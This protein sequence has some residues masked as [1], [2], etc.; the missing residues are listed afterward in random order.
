[1]DYAHVSSDG[2]R[3]S[4]TLH[5]SIPRMKEAGDY[6]LFLGLRSDNDYPYMNASVIVEQKLMPEGHIFVDTVKIDLTRS[7]GRSR[8]TGVNLYQF[9]TEV[10]TLYLDVDDSLE[11]SIRHDIKTDTLRGISDVGVELMK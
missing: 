6:C 3:R 4:D 5:F 10:D 2:W 1:M 8:G 9:M 7:N 11:I